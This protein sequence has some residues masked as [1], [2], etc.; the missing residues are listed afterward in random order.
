MTPTCYPA[1][2]AHAEIHFAM[3]ECS[4][5]ALLVAK[6]DQDICAILRGDDPGKLARVLEDSFPHAN[7]IG[8]LHRG[9]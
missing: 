5:G 9:L 6:S 8:G 1:G 3:G 4:L 7:L 2:G